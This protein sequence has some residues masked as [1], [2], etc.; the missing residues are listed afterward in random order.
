MTERLS[1]LRRVLETTFEDFAFMFIHSIPATE[2]RE[3]DAETYIQ[4]QITFVTAQ[5]KGRL[6]A[7]A[8]LDFCQ[9]LSRNVLGLEP[10]EPLDSGLAESGLS[11]LVN[12]A[13]G[14]LAEALYGV[15]Q[16]VDLQPPKCTLCT[17]QAWEEATAADGTL[18]LLVD[19]YPVVFQLDVTQGLD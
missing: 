8:S 2:A 18:V 14:P 13:C 5:E 16:V 12:V 3:A 11:E 10:D 17:G 4:A 9:E 1:I 15:D 19:D 6:T 7:L